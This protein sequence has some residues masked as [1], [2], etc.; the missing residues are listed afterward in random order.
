MYNESRMAL[1]MLQLCYSKLGSINQRGFLRKFTNLG[2]GQCDLKERI[3]SSFI[4]FS[5]NYKSE[6]TAAMQFSCE[7]HQC[8]TNLEMTTF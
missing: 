1:S 7:R 5:F 3:Q 2:M 4:F 8:L 6:K